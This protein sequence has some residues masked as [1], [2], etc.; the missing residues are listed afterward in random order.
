M[1]HVSDV[2]RYILGRMGPMSAMKLQKL[3]YYS[4]AWHLVWEDRPLFDARIEAWA[5]G[6]VCTE[7]YDLH[8][9]MF[10][11]APADIVG[12]QNFLDPREMTTI[13]SVMAFYGGQSAM[14][15]SDLTHRERPWAGARGNL[16][17]GERS[18][19]EITHAA[20]AEYYGSL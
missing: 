19:A 6:P 2:A 9:G 20:M 14:Y 18:N 13:E 8:R 15:L 12:G 5:N 16:R 11:V 10:Q 17:P 3:V 1:A 4:Q 7:L